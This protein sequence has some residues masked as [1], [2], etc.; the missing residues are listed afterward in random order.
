[1]WV[2]RRVAIR[3]HTAEANMFARRALIALAVV[4]AMVLT[5]LSNLY[6][7][8]VEKFSDYQTR[9]DGNRIKVQP[10]PPNRGLIYDT[11]GVLLAENHPVYSLE[12]VAEDV[13]NIDGLLAQIEAL[14]PVSHEQKKSF[15]RALKQ[16]RRRRFKP[17]ALIERL[18]PEEAAIIA[19][20]QHQ[21]DGVVIDAHLKRFYPHG[22]L[23]THALGYVAKINPKDAAR[24]EANNEKA[25][26]AATR[27][28]GKQGL[29]KF[30]QNI[31]HGTVGYRKVEVNS[32]G[33]VLREMDS[34]APIPGNDLR[35]H[36]D[37]SLQ[38]LAQQLL[39]DNR[40]AVVMLDAVNNGILALYSNPSYD[41]NLFVHG[42][43]GKD[44]RALL[45]S[46]DR[47]LINRA[48]QGQ[49]PPAST[50]KPLIGLLGLEKGLVTEQTTMW[51]PGYYQ[52]KGIEHKYRD[53]K[54]WGHG[55]VDIHKS[56]EESCDTYF[57]DLALRLGIDAI[58]EEMVKFGFGEATG[59]DIFEESSANMPSQQ[60]KRARYNQPWYAGDTISIGIGQGY[61]TSTPLQ[62]ALATSVLANEGNFNEPKFL[63]AIESNTG[64][65]DSPAQDR[66]PVAIQNK[67]NWQ[68]IKRAMY[69]TVQKVTGT[70]H[71]AF[72]GTTYDA[73][74]KTGTAQVISIA[75][76]AEY[77]ETK[78]AERHRDNALFVGFAPYDEPKVVIAVVV[79]NAGGGS[80]NAAPVARAMMDA[81]F[82][83][84]PL[85]ENP[86][87]D[88]PLAREP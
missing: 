25:N 88:L 33:R 81:Y 19:V 52:I 11:N 83:S 16:N 34:Q 49:Y 41:P 62:L 28:I 5:L 55:H 10:V 78:I 58:S 39:A 59:V 63:K 18:T 44:Y 64:T 9:A 2:K 54:K 26:Y 69:T 7:L 70:A 74:G 61:W 20:N 8:Q 48:T 29:E 51:D 56:I 45:Q 24:I 22:D 21:L 12:I 67:E 60:W 32:R 17:I 66:P 47:P 4:L 37:I 31:L 3:D 43:S 13:K 77:D 75:Q 23:L 15:Y 50:I 38:K 14:I 65:I 27:D 68:I 46:P 82:A 86:M 42:I 53:W 6:H 72:K 87:Q 79:E 57:Y 40:G 1:M 85:G 73:A 84:N 36:L 80:S 76:D 35:L 30:Y 71:K